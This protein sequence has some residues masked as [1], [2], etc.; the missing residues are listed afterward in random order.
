MDE[1]TLKGVTAE[2]ATLTL[3]DISGIKASLTKEGKV[4]S[5]L[6]LGFGS[7]DPEIRKIVVIK[8]RKILQ[9]LPPSRFVQPVVD[10]GLVPDLVSLLDSDDKELQ[11]EAAWIVANIASGTTQQ[12][13]K[14]IDAGAIPKLV[15]LAV[16]PNE[17]ISDDAV[18]AL[19]NI[20]GDS[21]VLRDRVEDEGGIN[22]LVTIL[23]HA[24]LGSTNTQRRAVWAISC[25]LQPWP[26]RRLPV[27]RVKHLLPCLVRYISKAPVDEANMESL[28]YAVL[29]LRRICDRH[30][31]RS[32]FIETEVVHRLVQL[33][34]D[35]SSSVTLK[36]QALE[37][38]G[39]LVGGDDKDTDVAMDAGLLPALSAALADGNQ[40]VCELACWN[41]SN[42]AAGNQRQ[43]QAFLE[44]GLLDQ[45]VRILMD[46]QTYI[47][48]RREACWVI[49]NLTEKIA[50]DTIGQTLI[51]G[52]CLEG[53]SAA[54]LI[55]D[56][57]AKERAVIGITSLLEWRGA[58]AS[59]ADSSALAAIRNASCPQ[60]LRAVRDSR[61]LQD[62]QL[63]KDCH[64][65]LTRY[66]PEYS[67][68]ARV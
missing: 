3:Q 64:D 8:I 1:E 19:A 62:I 18:W 9:K 44:S 31:E 65:I 15:R 14:V 59:E 52:P 51:K 36:K 55:P 35:C 34:A 21:A 39:Y 27:T 30:L 67:R 17:A 2:L 6:V 13:E 37:C 61:E 47:I 25:Y 49:S 60:N 63:K 20:V 12:T 57:Q 33:L 4:P 46:G 5:G 58:Q 24:D 23:N 22:A 7:E 50:D 41:A 43:V 32:D 38:L 28:E 66:F 54:L 48:C 42:I 56:R 11:R 40:Q 45:V 10:T 26:S 53:L 68:R 16:S 29:S